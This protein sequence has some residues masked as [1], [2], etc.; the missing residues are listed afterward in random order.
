MAG[1]YLP[2]PPAREMQMGGLLTSRQRS[3]ARR[4][5]LVEGA[6]RFTL[7]CQRAGIHK[8]SG[9]LADAARAD[10]DGR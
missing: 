2:A 9:C 8:L 10:F 7:A 1:L 4:R 5:Q 6:A 3:P